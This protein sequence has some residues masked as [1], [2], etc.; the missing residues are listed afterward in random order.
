M[1]RR[2]YQGTESADCLVG[3][4]RAEELRG[5]AGDDRLFGRA[6]DDVLIGGRGDDRLDGG[7]GFDTADYRRAVTGVIADLTAGR[8][9][10]GQGG[11]DRLVAIEALTGSAFDDTLI[12]S[13]GDNALVGGDGQDILAPGAGSDLVDGGAGFDYVDYR[14]SA[15]AV[16]VDLTL[17]F[18]FER[19]DMGGRDALVGIEG[20]YGSAFE[21]GMTAADG[22]VHFVG[23]D[24]YDDLVG[25]AGN[26]ILEGGDGADELTG[27]RGADTLYGGRGAD[28]FRF[29]DALDVGDRSDRTDM[30]VDFSQAEHDR[31]NL[32]RID[33]DVTTDGQQAF[34]FIGDSGFS[35]TAG[36]LK[37]A[38]VGDG[39]TVLMADV[40]GDALADGYIRL[41]GTIA[42][43][44]DDFSPW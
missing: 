35:G 43:T 13:S 21:D 32:A 14:E 36:E 26:D 7:L 39:Q 40:D 11:T 29:A 34:T 20:V 42:F 38:F 25:G 8:A 10:D 18:A 3:S 12:G 16:T 31:I 1:R 15:L 24:G 27:G 37:Y 5:L 6:G 2:L 17:G 44:A 28:T 23:G 4:W 9:S 33:A 41:N 19:S 22:A 30:I